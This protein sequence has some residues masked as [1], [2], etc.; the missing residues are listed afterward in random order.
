MGCSSI[1]D[2]INKSYVPHHVANVEW[3]IQCLIK[4]I[5]RYTLGRK[6]DR[7][8][9]PGDEEDADLHHGM[10]AYIYRL[11]SRLAVAND[12]IRQSKL[13]Q[14]SPLCTRLIHYHHTMITAFER[15]RTIREYRT[16]R[17]LK[18]HTGPPT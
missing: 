8:A 5:I 3:H 1:D 14:N 9:L 15:M 18:I 4:S 7:G 10:Q 16:P 17:Y 6:N 12:V 13:K 2:T 11:F